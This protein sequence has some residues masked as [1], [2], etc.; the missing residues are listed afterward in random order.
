M[1]RERKLAFPGLLLG[2]TLLE[3]RPAA[4]PDEVVIGRETFW[5]DILLSRQHG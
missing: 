2:F 3:Y 4:T 5:K 1:G